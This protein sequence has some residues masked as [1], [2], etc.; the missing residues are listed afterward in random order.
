[1]DLF[2]C[3]CENTRFDVD[4]FGRVWYPDLG[5]FR[6]AVLDTNGNDLTHFGGYGNADSRGPESPI[7][8]AETGKPRP[9][10]KDEKNPL[11]EPDIAF[12]WLIGVG[13][14]DKY[15]Y[16]GDSMNRRLLRAKITYVAEETCS[17]R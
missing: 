15:V 13:A 14:T 9:A 11:A 2:Y 1:V 7:I 3:N 5:R 16:M 6:V 17:I 8:D 4:L 10:K 12:S